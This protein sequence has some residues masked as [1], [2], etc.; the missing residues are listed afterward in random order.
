MQRTRKRG[1]HAPRESA[2]PPILTSRVVTEHARVV[3]KKKEK[4]KNASYFERYS[5][6]WRDASRAI[7]NTAED[8]CDAREKCKI[9]GAMMMRR[10]RRAGGCVTDFSGR[11]DVK[12]ARQGTNGARCKPSVHI[13][14]LTHTHTH[15]LC[16]RTSANERVCFCGSIT[17]PSAAVGRLAYFAEASISRGRSNFNL[18][19]CERQRR[20]NN[21]SEQLFETSSR[22]TA[23]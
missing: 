17:K 11:S 10:K 19:T 21:G 6:T 18:N 15:T 14:R 5:T 12:I 3:E 23:G 4:T 9:G 16:K 2:L 22:C 20:R 7:G 1:F 8:R 13:F